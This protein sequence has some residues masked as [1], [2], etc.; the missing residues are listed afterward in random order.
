MGTEG[1]FKDYHAQNNTITSLVSSRTHA[2]LEEEDPAV[3]SAEVE[4]GSDQY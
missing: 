2:Q 3:E 4:G 1:G